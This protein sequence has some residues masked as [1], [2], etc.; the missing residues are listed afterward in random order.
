MSSSCSG[1]LS[2]APNILAAFQYAES[3]NADVALA[4]R[5]TVQGRSGAFVEVDSGLHSPIEQTAGIVTDSK[6]RREAEQF[7]E[8]LSG[9]RGRALLERFGYGIP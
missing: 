8:F 4:A 7:L 3:G 9:E 5:S 1:W 2:H 6:R